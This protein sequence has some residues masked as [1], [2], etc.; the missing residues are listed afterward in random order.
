M[1]HPSSAT[2]WDL[3]DRWDVAGDQALEL[4]GYQRKL[5][6]TDW[7]PRFRLSTEFGQADK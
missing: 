5:P 1:P 3:M 6:T 4:V 7:R 2:F